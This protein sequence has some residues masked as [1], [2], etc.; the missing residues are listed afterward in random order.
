[1]ALAPQA[2]RKT[3]TPRVLLRP[4]QCLLH[5]L[6]IHHYASA[7]ANLRQVVVSVGDYE[8][9]REILD[10]KA[11]ATSVSATDTHERDMTR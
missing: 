4:W 9:G 1:M 2:A 10:R 5:L 7:D 6:L 11:S 3:W 8:L